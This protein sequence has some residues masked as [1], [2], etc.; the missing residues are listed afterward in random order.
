MVTNP[1]KSSL[2]PL[3]FYFQLGFIEKYL[4]IT[5]KIT[6]ISLIL[7]FIRRK[8]VNIPKFI[9]K[10]LYQNLKTKFRTILNHANQCGTEKKGLKNSHTPTNA[11]CSPSHIGFLIKKT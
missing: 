10:W 3:K 4:L 2:N 6:K 7:F 8:I 9:K 1:L 5:K 11:F